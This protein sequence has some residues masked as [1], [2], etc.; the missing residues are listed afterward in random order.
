MVMAV[1]FYDSVDFCG[2]QIYLIKTF[3]NVE[4]FLQHAHELDEVDYGVIM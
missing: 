1:Q 4:Q 2:Y 3:I